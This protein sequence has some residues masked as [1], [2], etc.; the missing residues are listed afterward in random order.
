MKT[1]PEAGPE[2]DGL[3]ARYAMKGA[4]APYS[5]DTEAALRAWERVAPRDQ[6]AVGWIL[7]PVWGYEK[8]GDPSTLRVGGW[9]VIDQ[10]V[11]ADGQPSARRVAEA[12]TMALAI[13]RAVWKLVKP[14]EARVSHWG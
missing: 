1:N 13:C 3:I 12:D 11:G 6:A 9:R 14:L 4:V 7:A 8:A 5:T 10:S 2:F